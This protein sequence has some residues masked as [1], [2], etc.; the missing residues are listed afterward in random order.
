MKKLLL[1]FLLLGTLKIYG[2]D[3]QLH[4]DLG[5]DRKYFTTTVE[6]F[7]PDKFGSTF[8]FINMD[9]NV[10]KVKGVSA[11]YWEISR[12]LKFWQLPLL[13]HVE[14]NGGFGQFYANNEERAFTI[15]D[16]WLTG[17]TYTWD[18]SD[19]TKGFSVKALYKYIRDKTNL[20]YQLTGVWHADLLNEKV[21]FEG[22][23]DFWRENKDFNFDGITDTKFVLISEPKLWYNFTDHF[24][25]GSKIQLTNNFSSVKGFR[26]NPTIAVKYVF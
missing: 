24:S 26:V 1:L 23:V 19:L 5:K 20:S 7:K 17:I 21:L 6:M 14:Y 11:A 4:Y 10:D 25:C 22:F 2:Q 18:N 15:N 3:I 8:F 9:Y 16:A 12:D 13:F